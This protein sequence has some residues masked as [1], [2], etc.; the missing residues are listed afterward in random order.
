MRGGWPLCFSSTPGIS[1]TQ[2]KIEPPA[3]PSTQRNV[4]GHG[5]CSWL[6]TSLYFSLL[7]LVGSRF[8]SVCLFPVA[9]R[10]MSWPSVS[11][12]PELA[13]PGV[14]V[15]I[16]P[17]HLQWAVWVSFPLLLGQLGQAWQ[18]AEH[19]QLPV[20]YITPWQEDWLL[21]MKSKYYLEFYNSLSKTSR[22]NFNNHLLWETDEG[23]KYH[24]LK[25]TKTF[26]S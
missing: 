6:A 2:W 23:G 11:P 21:N 17:S 25:Y 12:L 26:C 1:R 15:H 22:H 24:H 18:K 9:V 20:P 4:K 13:G 8:L 7:V 10:S 14:E 16:H 19:T 3:P 5:R